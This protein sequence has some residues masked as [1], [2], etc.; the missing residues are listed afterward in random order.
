MCSLRRRTFNRSWTRGPRWTV[1]VLLV[2]T[3]MIEKGPAATGR[4]LDFGDEWNQMETCWPLIATNDARRKR[5]R[6]MKMHPKEK[7]NGRNESH[8][9]ELLLPTTTAKKGRKTPKVTPTM[10]H[11]EETKARQTNRNNSRDAWKE[12]KRKRGTMFRE[13]ENSTAIANLNSEWTAHGNY[14]LQSIRVRMSV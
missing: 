9:M 6:K 11:P 12:K 3:W 4:T 7:P 1:T 5:H 10:A 8:W 13:K 14:E 2:W